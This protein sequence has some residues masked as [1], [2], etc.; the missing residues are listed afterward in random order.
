MT[1]CTKR[2]LCA[3]FSVFLLGGGVQAQSAALYS[4][5]ENSTIGESY[6]RA[7]AGRLA[8][9]GGKLALRVYKSTG[10]QDSKGAF[11]SGTTVTLLPRITGADYAA[12]L[13]TNGTAFSGRGN[14]STGGDVSAA[15]WPDSSTVYT[16]LFPN[17]R[18]IGWANDINQSGRLVFHAQGSS[19][20]QPVPYWRNESGG[21]VTALNTAGYT[22]GK[23]NGINSSNVIGGE[24]FSNSN[25][26]DR[27]PCYWT[28]N[29]GISDY[30]APTQLTGWP[31]GRSG[32]VIDVGD[33][34]VL[35]GYMDPGVFSFQLA[36][37]FR[38]TVSTATLEFIGEPGLTGMPAQAN[39]DGKIV[40]NGPHP[41]VWLPSA[42]PWNGAVLDL[43]AFTE[44]DEEEEEVSYTLTGI[45][46][47]SANPR[48]GGN[49]TNRSKAFTTVEA[50]GWTRRPLR[51]T[52]AGFV[53]ENFEYQLPSWL[54]SLSPTFGTEASPDVEGTAKLPDAEW[55][56]YESLVPAS[57]S[58]ASTRL[59]FYAK[60]GMD[61]RTI[62]KLG[63]KVT[64]RCNLPTSMSFNLYLF[65]E[66]LMD[67][68]WVRMTTQDV[69]CSRGFRT[70]EAYAEG[71]EARQFVDLSSML[72]ADIADINLLV[73]SSSSQTWPSNVVL[74][75]D[76]ATFYT[77]GP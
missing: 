54:G 7:E 25:A 34:G 3:S 10:G 69:P 12:A 17:S 61:V 21:G 44:P 31:S 26:S 72:D 70:L 18:T 36:Q 13:S 37:P 63:V 75:I 66:N 23:A 58:P 32:T 22:Y 76:Q 46:D 9:S 1:P 48:F 29:S 68:E 64:L 60:C 51:S 52:E 20:P 59:A 77:Q 73:V 24:V 53:G 57:D 15:Y 11:L 16:T 27:V 56:R 41:W 47:G 38:Y 71:D 45:D 42:S 30:N 49:A 5:T 55:L 39:A 65:K 14:T 50:S 28:Y 33:N 74:D 62:N 35:V 40:G 43:E 67:S 8:P 6:D 19:S 2:R 4:L